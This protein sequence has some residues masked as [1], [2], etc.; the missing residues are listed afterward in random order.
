MEPSAG[1][2][3]LISLLRKERMD[4]R[5]PLYAEH[6]S[7]D[8]KTTHFA[9]WEMPVSYSAGP[10]AEHRRVRAA[11][12]LFDLSHMGRV[13]VSGP[14]ARA[15][16]QYVATSNVARLKVGDAIYAPM[17]YADG[18][19]VDDAFVYRL[20]DAYLVVVN[21]SNTAK[22]VNWLQYQATGQDVQIVDHSAETCMLA[23]QGPLAESILQRVCDSDLS[24]LA[25][26]QIQSAMVL[27]AEILV[28]RTGYT[29]EDGFEL[30]VPAE[31]AVMLWRGLLAEGESDGI[32]P[33]GLAA[34][35]SLRFEPCFAL[36]GHEIDASITPLQ[37][38]LSWA[39]ALKK[40]P[41]VGRDALIKERLEGVPRRLAGFEM[42]DR[43][44]PRHG[45]SVL[46]GEEPV[47]WVTSGL[48]A[49][50]LDRFLGLAY[51]SPDSAAPGT[52][53]AIDVRGQLRRARI[54]KRPFYT[55]SYQNK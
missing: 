14:D 8:A 17:C 16:L 55:P 51:V 50:T 3:Y 21:A 41:F 43:G 10:V 29:G 23:L 52:E 53:I 28:G 18:G 38:G 44:V 24:S 9:G 12:G 13:Y 4:K 39:V 6:L 49:P 26:N 45:M 42:I 36:Y 27:D 25:R 37:A 5:T 20:A 46:A 48:Y 32:L 7:L 47:G 1:I 54:V 22:D 11:A 30:Y 33:I 35:D 40:G 34:R 15:L 2:N 31:S 19:L